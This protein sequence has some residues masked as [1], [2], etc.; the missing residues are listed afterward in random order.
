MEDMRDSTAVLQIVKIVRMFVKFHPL[1]TV[2]SL[3]FGLISLQDWIEDELSNQWKILKVY[4]Q[5]AMRA[6]LDLI[7]EKMKNLCEVL[8][9]HLNNEA[10]KG[11]LKA[12]LIVNSKFYVE[13]VAA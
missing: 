8:Q 11:Q 4:C 1:L 3:I 12:K 2:T 7:N 10:T 9:M 5:V 13:G 6:L